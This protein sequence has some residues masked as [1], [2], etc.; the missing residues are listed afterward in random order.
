MSRRLAVAF[1][2]LSAVWEASRASYGSDYRVVD[3]THTQDENA[4]GGP[5]FKR[6]S[7]S[8]VTKGY[9]GPPGQWI[10]VYE[11]SQNEHIGT[12]M[13]APSHF[14]K[15]GKTIDQIPLGKMAGPGVV[16]DVP[17][18]R[19][20]RNYAVTVADL[21]RWEAD[22]GRIPLEAVVVL[23]TGKA[24]LYGE[25]WRYYGWASPDMGENLDEAKFHNPG[26]NTLNTSLTK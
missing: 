1:L 25:S 12:H 7:R 8:T 4:Y 20:D 6:L 10:E 23:R 21:E 24:E 26:N 11:F 15:G 16:V 17:A 2:L 9:M 3:L 22:H 13:D 14:T 18:D 5:A 19:G